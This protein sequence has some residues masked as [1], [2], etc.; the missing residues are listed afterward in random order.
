MPLKHLTIILIL[1]AGVRRMVTGRLGITPYK[2]LAGSTPLE[3]PGGILSL[4]APF[5]MVRVH[6]EIREKKGQ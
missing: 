4:H 6:P 5:L 3:R 1:I 2:R